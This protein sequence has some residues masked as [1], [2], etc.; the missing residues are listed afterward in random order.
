MQNHS[1]YHFF[2]SHE[3]AAHLKNTSILNKEIDNSLLSSNAPIDPNEILSAYLPLSHFLLINVKSTKRT[4]QQY[5]KFLN[6][7]KRTK[8]PFIIGIT[9]SV[10]SGKST[11]S[12]VLCTLLQQISNFKVS[13]VTTDGFLFPNAILEKKKLLK[14]KGFP[15]SYDLNKLL[16]FLSEI[17]SGRTEVFAPRYSHSQYDI[18]EE[19]YDK[20]IQPDILLLE[21]INILQSNIWSDNHK[22]MPLVSDFLDFSIY[23]DATEQAIHQWY[24]NRFLGLRKEG[25]LNPNSYFHRF[26]E[27]SESQSLQ[28]AET[29]WADI[30]LPNLQQNILPTR[31]SAN[32]ILSKGEN[33]LIETIAIRKL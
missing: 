18:L 25:F 33:H 17:K 22:T 16:E 5:N 20:I 8:T 21:G 32:I 14:R 10:S 31:K 13:L 6:I 30:N 7:K 4:Y 12:R 29:S 23:I 24:L 3:W 27:I 28:I 9:G 2:T 11:I 26:T 19:E 15:E 1:L